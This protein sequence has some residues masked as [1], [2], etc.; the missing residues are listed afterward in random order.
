[1]R[2]GAVRNRLMVPRCKRSLSN[3]LC[4]RTR[5]KPRNG[6]CVLWPRALDLSFSTVARVWRAHGLKPHLVRPFK[7]SNDPRFAEKLED[8]IAFT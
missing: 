5:P 4:S 8:V 7:V 2:Q 6:A 1:M 3:A